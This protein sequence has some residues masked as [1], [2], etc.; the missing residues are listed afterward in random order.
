MSLY[1]KEYVF[2]LQGICLCILRNMSL[3][4]KE[5]SL[6]FKEYVSVFQGIYLC[7]IKNMSLYY[8]EYVYVF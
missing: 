6:Y 2:V 5:Y 8:K 1:Y 7:I 4:F 3:Y